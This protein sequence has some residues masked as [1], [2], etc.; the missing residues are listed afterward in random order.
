[1]YG[2]PGGKRPVALQPKLDLIVLFHGAEIIREKE[3]IVQP[4][5]VEDE[6][7]GIGAPDWTRT[8]TPSRAQALNLLRIPIP[9]Q[10][11]HLLLYSLSQGLSTSGFLDSLRLHA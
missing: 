10:G 7:A 11:L 3:G 8:S 5:K 6:K 1:M 4:S 2:D 9:P